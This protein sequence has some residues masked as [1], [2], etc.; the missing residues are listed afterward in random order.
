MHNHSFFKCGTKR[1]I[2]HEGR[3]I[4]NLRRLAR[5]RGFVFIHSNFE[6][7]SL[8]EQ[9]FTVHDADIVV[10]QHG[11][12]LTHIIFTKPFSALFELFPYGFAAGDYR[13]AALFSGKSYHFWQNTNLRNDVPF[14]LNDTGGLQFLGRNPHMYISNQDM[15]EISSIFDHLL[16]MNAATTRFDFPCPDAIS[17][18]GNE[19]QELSFPCFYLHMRDTRTVF[20]TRKRVFLAPDEEYMRSLLNASTDR[21]V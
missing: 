15:T 3:F 17:L 9:I 20:D 2:V 11:M 1:Q 13:N 12:A 4:S 18:T 16:L 8:Q 21:L 14:C 10:G 6:T 5:A 19:L 7:L